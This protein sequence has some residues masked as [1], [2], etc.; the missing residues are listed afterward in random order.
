V[1]ETDAAPSKDT[2]MSAVSGGLGDGEDARD[3]FA[4]VPTGRDDEPRC[5]TI[6]WCASHLTLTTTA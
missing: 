5:G 3:V 1:S 4:V 6:W 2:V